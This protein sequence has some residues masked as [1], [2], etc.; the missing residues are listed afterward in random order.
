M[1]P[2]T[3]PANKQFDIL[4][5]SNQ[6]N[7]REQWQQALAKDYTTEHV[8]NLALLLDVIGHYHPAMLLLDRNLAG[9]DY[10]E[11][12]LQIHKASPQTRILIMHDGND[13]D[14]QV[15]ALK[16]G[17]KGYC[18]HATVTPE[19][20][21]KAVKTIKCNE[22][23]LPRRLVPQIIEELAVNAATE[24]SE[25][26]T[27]QIQGLNSMT[28]RQREVIRMVCDGANNKTIADQLAISE[29]TVKT[30]LSAIFTKLGVQ[31]RLHLALLLKNTE[32]L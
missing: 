22:V 20:L 16:M 10:L 11:N 14:V 17:V 25:L 4:I 15:E 5:A 28:P 30:H 18:N 24:A 27:E 7:A 23:W 6:A 21:V 29:R 1:T 13:E 2:G 19:L 8:S 31:S 32:N 9:N 26:T 12:V 3:S